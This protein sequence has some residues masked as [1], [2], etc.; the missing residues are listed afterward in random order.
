MPRLSTKT[1]YRFVFMKQI[2][3]LYFYKFKNTSENVMNTDGKNTTRQ[4]WILGHSPFE[5]DSRSA[6]HIV[7]LAAPRFLADWQLC[8][9][10]AQIPMHEGYFDE[11]L[12]ILLTNITLMEASDEDMAPWINE[13][14][15][16]IGYS[17][18]RV[19]IQH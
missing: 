5:S 11:E 8:D 16:V 9:T 14:V 10:P 19:A 17:L 3:P 4:N 13:A 15:N 6:G 7:H 18:G 2:A 12:S 1:T